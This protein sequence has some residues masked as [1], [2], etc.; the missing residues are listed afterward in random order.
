MDYSI[1]ECLEEIH[2]KAKTLPPPPKP[3]Y[4]QCKVLSDLDKYDCYPEDGSNQDNC[5]ARGCCWMPKPGVQ[6]SSSRSGVNVPL[7][8]PYCFYPLNYSTYTYL[9]VT[10]TAFGLVAFM[11][12]NYRSPYSDDV[13]TI[14]MTVKFE[15]E[16][17]LHVKVIYNF[18]CSN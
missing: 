4:D 7:D 1:T 5:E 2:R 17:R 8:V 14:R 3:D 13:E 12:R 6:R 16:H 15:T 9:N 10:E 11:K 18:I